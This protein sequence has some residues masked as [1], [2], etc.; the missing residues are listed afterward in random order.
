MHT[1]THA[2]GA[3]SVGGWSPDIAGLAA[4]TLSAGV[5]T[6][7]KSLAPS[8]ARLHRGRLLFVVSFSCTR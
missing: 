2:V 3:I 6:P 1:H 4:D 5:R 8:R 7:P